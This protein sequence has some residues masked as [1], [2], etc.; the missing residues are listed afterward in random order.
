M[1]KNAETKK[2]TNPPSNLVVLLLALRCKVRKKKC[3]YQA[4][5]LSLSL[6]LSSIGE[7]S[8]RRGRREL[9]LVGSNHPGCHFQPPGIPYGYHVGCVPCGRPGGCVP[10][11]RLPGG[12]HAT[13]QASPGYT[14]NRLRRS[15]PPTHHRTRCPTGNQHLFLFF[16]A[17]LATSQTARERACVL[18]PP[19]R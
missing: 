13:R 6:S 1:I 7:E 11:G 17:L 5:S 18:A 9:A 3:V 8:E 2:K 19:R 15:T 4:L 14:S 16:Q 10:C 12:G